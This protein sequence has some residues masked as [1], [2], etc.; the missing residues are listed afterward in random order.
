LGSPGVW[1]PRCDVR[2]V[3]VVQDGVVGAGNVD[4]GQQIHAEDYT[5]IGVVQY[6]IESACPVEVFRTRAIVRI[7]DIDPEGI[8]SG[9][10]HRLRE[11]GKR[12]TAPVK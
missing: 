4:L 5:V 3:G 7:I 8:P 6:D 1:D 10:S 11:P 9:L 12:S 2:G